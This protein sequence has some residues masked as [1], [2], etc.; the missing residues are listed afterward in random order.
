MVFRSSD[1]TRAAKGAEA[2]AGSSPRL[3]QRVFDLLAAQIAGG[4]LAA[5]ARLSETAVAAHF[6]TSRAPARRA[7]ADLERAGLLL[8]SPAPSHGY[9][10]RAG[11]GEA[12]PA[13]GSPGALPGAGVASPSPARPT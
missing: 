12:T 6:G 3:H 11:D 9:V 5:G 10:V 2:T 4:V 1:E 13:P 7:L 8:R